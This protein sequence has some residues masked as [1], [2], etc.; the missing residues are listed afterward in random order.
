MLPHM[1]RGLEPEVE[2]HFPDWAEGGMTVD[3]TTRSLTW[4]CEAPVDA[5]LSVLEVL[6]PLQRALWPGW[7]VRWATRGLD[8]LLLAVGLPPG[9]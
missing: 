3:L 2:D 9:P 6:L 4:F 8:D 1:M 5:C 7:D